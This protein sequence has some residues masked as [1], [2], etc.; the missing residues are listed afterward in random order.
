MRFRRRPGKSKE[1]SVYSKIKAF[2]SNFGKK[3]QA[4]T[5]SFEEKV[6]SSNHLFSTDFKNNIDYKP[7][8]LAAFDHV[9]KIKNPVASNNYATDEAYKGEAMDDGNGSYLPIKAAFMFNSGV[10]QNQLLW[11]G[12][13][14]FIN[15]QICSILGQHWLIS[16][17]CLLP[18]K[19]AIRN[20]FDIAVKDGTEIDT[21]IL[22]EIKLYDRKFRLNKNLI[23]LIQM[24]K[25]FGIRIVIFKIESDDPD[26][27]LK[28]F[29]IDGVGPG[30]YKGMSQIDP[31][32]IT[33]QLDDEAASDPSSIHFYEPT[34]WR[35]NGK[36]YH[37]THLIIYRTEEVSDILKPTYIYGGIPI[38]QKIYERVYAAERTANEAPMLAL[39]KRT[40][41]IKTDVTEFLG[42]QGEAE[43]ALKNWAFRRDNYGIKVIGLNDE[44]QQFDTS[45][46]ELDAA[47]MTQY[48][49]VAAA[50]NVP[51]VKLLGTPPKGFNA[52][53]EFEEASYHEELESIQTHDLLPLIERHHELLSRSY[54]LPRF[55]IEPVINVNFNPLDALTKK[56]QAEIN[57]MK[58]QTGQNLMAM[59][60]INSEDE[61]N[62]IIGDIESGYNGLPGDIEVEEF[63][64]ISG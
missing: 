37:R 6:R 12:S 29:N 31:Y 62:R 5:Y 33:P 64:P 26:F 49:L 39:T 51:A 40:D 8:L 7:A 30:S 9:F 36:L 20:G 43:Q 59:G 54:I 24:G 48:Q 50:A 63:D 61:R 11:Y 19:D 53:G 14:T 42:N 32:W 52:T 16:K 2:F 44:M 13:Q 22:E 57:L 38:P 60:A 3:T 35:I 25:I 28:P 34:W 1:L 45:L 46:A 18:A 17:C 27:Y 41:V 23:E 47:I 56:E 10:P 21:E 58:S 15:Y 4:N 55:G